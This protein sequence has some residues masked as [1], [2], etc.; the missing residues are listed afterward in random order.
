MW[1]DGSDRTVT[2]LEP[3]RRSIG[4]YSNFKWVTSQHEPES[5]SMYLKWG[6]AHVDPICLDRNRSSSGDGRGL[7]TREV[8]QHGE[9]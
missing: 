1:T 3:E 8:E 2:V 4:S 7:N 9:S 5:T 6:P